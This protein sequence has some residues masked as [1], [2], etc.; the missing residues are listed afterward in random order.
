MQ[1]LVSY[2]TAVEGQPDISQM[3]G[4]L[5]K[6]GDLCL[7]P[8]LGECFGPDAQVEQM[9]IKAVMPSKPQEPDEPSFSIALMTTSISVHFRPNNFGTIIQIVS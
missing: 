4:Q 9:A 3:S 2:I 6:Q 8:Q 1:I 5:H 7:F